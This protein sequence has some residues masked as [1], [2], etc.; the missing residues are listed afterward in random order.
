MTLG[1]SHSKG[2]EFPV[3]ACAA[4]SVLQTLKSGSFPSQTSRLLFRRS[5]SELTKPFEGCLFHIV[6]TKRRK[7][8]KVCLFHTHP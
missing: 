7:Y 6:P 4:T 8:Y 3:L 1:C 5:P 2:V